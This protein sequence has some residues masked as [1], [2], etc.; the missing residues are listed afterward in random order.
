MGAPMT[1]GSKKSQEK[2]TS[3]VFCDQLTTISH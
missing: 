1:D 3:E 2:G